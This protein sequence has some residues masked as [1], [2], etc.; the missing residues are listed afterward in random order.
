MCCN[1]RYLS[2]YWKICV[3]LFII[4]L[5]IR[6]AICSTL[7]PNPF[8]LKM[9]KTD[10]AAQ[11][12]SVNQFQPPLYPIFIRAVYCIFGMKNYRAVFIIQGIASALAAPLLF[13]LVACLGSLPAAYAAGVIAAMYPNFILHNLTLLESSFGILLNTLLMLIMLIECKESHRAIAAAVITGLG[14]MLM[15]VFLFILPGLLFILKERKVFLAVLFIMLLPLFIYN[16]KWHRKFVPIFHRWTW[17]IDLR[18]Y[19]AEGA[20]IIEK[21]YNNAAS[22][23]RHPSRIAYD[24]GIDRNV[25]TTNYV[26]YYSYIVLLITGLIGL[27][28]CY[29]R[30]HRGIVIPFLSFVLLLIFFGRFDIES[31]VLVE[32]IMVVYLS[33]LIGN[34]LVHAS[35][36]EQHGGVQDQRRLNQNT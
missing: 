8:S 1:V 22:L 6:I 21:I 33:I 10:H 4:A 9:K 16:V 20:R 23:F 24:E 25:L 29:R 28:R 19:Q 34:R 11:T 2:R 15:P 32:P 17:A 18:R 35:A 13:L 12:L 14:I 3:A 7:E 27:I 26:R 30:E 31:R 5:V 36:A